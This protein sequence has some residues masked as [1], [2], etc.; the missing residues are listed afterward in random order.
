[1]GSSTAGLVPSRERTAAL[2]SANQLT[3]A[4]GSFGHD[5]PVHAATADLALE[6]RPATAHAVML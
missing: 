2:T 5:S 1:V 3:Q 6:R 4:L